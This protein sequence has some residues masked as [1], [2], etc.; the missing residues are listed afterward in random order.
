MTNWMINFIGD[1][2]Y[3]PYKANPALHVEDLP[4]RAALAFTGQESAAINDATDSSH[5]SN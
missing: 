3:C 2:L 5:T 1:P 4:P